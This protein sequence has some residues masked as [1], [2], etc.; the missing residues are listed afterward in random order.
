MTGSRQMPGSAGRGCVAD[1][2]DTVA[3]SRSVLI[4]HGKEDVPADGRSSARGGDAAT[5]SPPRSISASAI[6]CST[7]GS[8]KRARAGTGRGRPAVESPPERASPSYPGEDS[9]ISD[10]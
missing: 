8:A 5:R 4:R 6:G 2:Q 9:R 3:G 7:A 1:V 10:P